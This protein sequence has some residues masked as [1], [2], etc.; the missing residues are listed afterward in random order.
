[1]DITTSTSENTSIDPTTGAKVTEKCVTV[2]E[3]NT[4]A[5]WV[6][7]LFGTLGNTKC[8]G[9]DGADSIKN[10]FHFRYNQRLS[11]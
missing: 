11:K 9:K 3:L 1:M 4:A 8:A 10:R 7:H 6:D 2:S 5:K